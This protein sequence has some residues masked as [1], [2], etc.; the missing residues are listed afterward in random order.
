[1]KFAALF[2]MTLYNLRST[3]GL[4]LLH[5]VM[6]TA[7]CEAVRWMV[8]TYP[9]LMRVEDVQRDSAVAIALKECAFFLLKYSEQNDGLLPD[10][11]S[12]EDEA[13]DQY[14]PE[15]GEIRDKV[16]L[17]G[18]FVPEA[19]EKYVLNTTELEHLARHGYFR[20]VKGTAE[21]VKP[22][23][24]ELKQK[25]KLLAAEAAAADLIERGWRA[26]AFLEILLRCNCVFLAVTSTVSTSIPL[27]YTGIDVEPPVV[28]SKRALARKKA[29]IAGRERASLYRKR[30]PEDKVVDNFESGQL[31]AWKIVGLDIPEVNLFIDP[32]GD[33]PPIQQFE[34]ETTEDLKYTV[35]TARRIMKASFS[36]LRFVLQLANCSC[37][38]YFYFLNNICCAL[39]R[40]VGHL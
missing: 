25:E 4:T 26:S 2:D 9:E 19:S 39:K 13:F 32:L 15:V 29:Q 12:Y 28:L 3:L 21:E 14:Y 36:F 7:N 10:G 17:Y 35:K 5:T 38:L 27:L 18:E 20:D 23:F 34:D 16:A 31:S 24:F 30:F 33:G 22:S 1:M 40:S 6:C 11:T 37:L 8:H